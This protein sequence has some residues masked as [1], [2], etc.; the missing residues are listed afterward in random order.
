MAS[1]NSHSVLKDCLD[2]TILCTQNFTNES[3]SLKEWQGSPQGS[4][5]VEY[6]VTVVQ[7]LTFLYHNVEQFSVISSSQDFI[8]HLV[9]VA[10]PEVKQVRIVSTDDSSLKVRLWI[11]IGCYTFGYSALLQKET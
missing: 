11:V 10:F 2:I 4:W 6:P 5:L 1:P 7:F 8:E 3:I 9:A